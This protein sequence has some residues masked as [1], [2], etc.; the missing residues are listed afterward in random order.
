MSDRRNS[1]NG[2]LA[3]PS[4]LASPSRQVPTPVPPP[5]DVDQV[6]SKRDVRMWILWNSVCVFVNPVVAFV[7]ITG[8]GPMIAKLVFVMALLVWWLSAIVCLSSAVINRALTPIG[9]AEKSFLAAGIMQVTW[10]LELWRR[11]RERGR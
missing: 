2:E 1:P 6:P 9:I 11:A 8:T 10:L 3:R 4:K 5:C 7:V